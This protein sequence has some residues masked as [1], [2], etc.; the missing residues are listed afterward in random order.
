MLQFRNAVEKYGYTEARL[1]KS[2]ARAT[3]SLTTPGV[4]GK[5]TLEIL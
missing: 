5:V 2:I 1:K 4:R 3:I